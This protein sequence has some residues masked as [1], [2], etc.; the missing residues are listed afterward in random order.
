MLLPLADTTFA[1][2]VHHLL[3][4]LPYHRHRRRNIIMVSGG[5]LLL[6]AVLRSTTQ[7]QQEDSPFP[8]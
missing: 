7:W 1:V 4:P 5:E 6:L 8:P 2:E 3:M